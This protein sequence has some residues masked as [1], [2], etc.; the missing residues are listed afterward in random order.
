[1]GIFGGAKGTGY[2]RVTGRIKRTR[3]TGGTGYREREEY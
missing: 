3:G 2:T 1:M